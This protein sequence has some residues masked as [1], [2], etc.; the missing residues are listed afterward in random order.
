MGHT[1]SRI[2]GISF[3][4]LNTVRRRL[5]GRIPSP[6][7]VRDRVW[8]CVH[9]IHHWNSRNYFAVKTL[10]LTRFRLFL[11]YLYFSLSFY[12]Y[13]SSFFYTLITTV[14]DTQF[15][16]SIVTC[17]VFFVL[18]FDWVW[19]LCL[20]ETNF[21]L[22]HC[23]PWSLHCMIVIDWEGRRILGSLE[24]WSSGSAEQVELNLFHFLGNFQLSHSNLTSFFLFL[25]SFL[26]P[27]T[28]TGPNGYTCF[29][30]FTII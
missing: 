1:Q 10:S 29:F 14:S 25:F 9:D 16:T 7:T 30:Y 28:G 22:F 23:E 17:I 15:L 4:L 8:Q 21:T 13:F 19:Q 18:V 20:R 6:L 2:N 5:I 27:S 3:D 11:V 26:S 24:H 12:F